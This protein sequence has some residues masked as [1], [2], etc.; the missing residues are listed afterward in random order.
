[1]IPYLN[2]K[3]MANSKVVALVV[4]LCNL[5]LVA[6]TTCTLDAS[7]TWPKCFQQG[8]DWTGDDLLSGLRFS[9]EACAEWCASHSS[10][11]A[12]WV[13]KEIGSWCH[14]KYMMGLERNKDSPLTTEDIANVE[15]DCKKNPPTTTVASTSAGA[16][17]SGDNAT[18]SSN[19]TDSSAS[20]TSNSCDYSSNTTW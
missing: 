7:S 9:R 14:L 6:A 13:Y 1:M 10:R 5:S 12:G 19:A 11:C 3:S 2:S 17:A 4:V 20:S 18:S 8:V 16:S 15:A